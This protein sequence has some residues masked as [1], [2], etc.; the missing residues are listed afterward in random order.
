MLRIQYKKFSLRFGEI[1]VRQIVNN[2]IIYVPFFDAVPE[3]SNDMDINTK[4]KKMK[5]IQENVLQKQLN[6]FHVQ[7]EVNNLN[8]RAASATYFAHPLFASIK[9]EFSI[10]LSL[11]RQYKKYVENSEFSKASYNKFMTMVFNLTII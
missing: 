2:V 11:N 7:A 1:G 8:H 9:F 6:I 4:I 10:A 3:K 5:P